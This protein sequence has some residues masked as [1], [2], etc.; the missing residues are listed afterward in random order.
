MSFT[1]RFSVAVARE[2]YGQSG[3]AQSSST[4]L[5]DTTPRDLSRLELIRLR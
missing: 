1:D 5:S 2:A 3:H 4:P